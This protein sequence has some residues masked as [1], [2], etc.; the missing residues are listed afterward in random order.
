SSHVDRFTSANDNEPDVTFLIENLKNMIMKKLSISCVT[1]SLTSLSVFSVSFSAALSQSSTSASVSDSSLTT[2]VPATLTPATSGFTVS[3]FVT[4][5]SH[6]KKIL[7]R[8]NES[9]LSRITLLLNSVK[10]VKDI[11]VF[12]N[13]N[14]NIILFYTCECEA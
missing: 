9:S 13:R 3:A 2:P 11:C 10:F 8:L 14:M 1:E 7:Y 5:S 6:F 4:S 12:R